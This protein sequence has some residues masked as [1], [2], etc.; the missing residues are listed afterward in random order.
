VVGTVDFFLLV[1]VLDC[2]SSREDT[3]IFFLF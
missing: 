1:G 3:V 2:S